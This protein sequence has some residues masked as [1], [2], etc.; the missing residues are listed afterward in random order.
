MIVND[1]STKESVE[2]TIS[3]FKIKCNTNR[4][5]NKQINQTNMH[6]CMHTQ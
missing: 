4:K 2:A 5:E 1:T 6:A 3:E